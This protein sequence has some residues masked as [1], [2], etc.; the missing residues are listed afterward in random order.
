MEKIPRALVFLLILVLT[1]CAFPGNLPQAPTPTVDEI[2]LPTGNEPVVTMDVPESHNTDAA[3]PTSCLRE[4][5]PDRMLILDEDDDLIETLTDFLN[6]GGYVERARIGLRNWNNNRPDDIALAHIDFD[7]DGLLDVVAAL[8]MDAAGPL[9]SRVLA[10]RCDAA[11]YQLAYLSPALTGS[12]PAFIHTIEDFTGDEHLDVFTLQESCGAHTCT[13]TPLMLTWRATRLEDRWVEP[14]DDLPTP[15][16]QR[17]RN[18]EG[19]PYISITAT[20]IQSAGAGP[21][22]GFSRDYQWDPD[23]AVMALQGETTLPAIYRIHVVY[24]A[25]RAFL[26]GEYRSAMDAYNRVI[27]D[28]S[29][30]DWMYGEE[31]YRRLSAY[32]L[33]RNML[34]HLVEGDHD[35]ARDAYQ[36]LRES[37]RDG[38][39]HPFAEMGAT[40]W[41]AYV[42]E[43]G[44]EAGC[45]AARAY[46]ERN[47]EETVDALYYGYANPA[48]T[49]MDLC[50]DLP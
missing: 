28:D 47:A 43:Q 3:E 18:E 5:D 33:F 50:P 2:V 26:N 1:G 29:L 31:G 41:E 19:I 27:E 6:T 17:M 23:T 4:T 39:G 34:L 8:R 38:P 9:E 25:D 30:D 37:H 49:I 35:L 10:L 15:I 13:V 44:L 21:L 24:D 42:E 20:A 16:V 36:M 12:R 48:Y 45:Q 22:R 46:A 32:A 40:F 11:E 7:G 14:T